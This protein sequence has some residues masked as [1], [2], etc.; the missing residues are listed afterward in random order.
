MELVGR[1]GQRWLR[2]QAIRHV[3]RVRRTLVVGRITT[4]L[5]D[6]GDR[7]AIAGD[8]WGELSAL[9]GAILGAGS[10]IGQ[11]R[12]VDVVER[13]RTVFVGSSSEALPLADLVGGVARSAGMDP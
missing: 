10:G 6:I 5:A 9:I 11:Q 4:L 13:Q 12:Q 1:S 8:L 3:R 2:P 7:R